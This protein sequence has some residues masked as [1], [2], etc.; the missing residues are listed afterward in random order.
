[1]KFIDL[2][3]PVDEKDVQGYSPFHHAVKSMDKV[4][5]KLLFAKGA[6]IDSVDLLGCTPLV[7]L[8]KQHTCI[9]DSMEMIKF[10]I[11]NGAD[12]HV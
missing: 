3:L 4:L 5:A 7:N 8:C 1:M 11:Q 6:I 12:I 10:L 2:G 9:E